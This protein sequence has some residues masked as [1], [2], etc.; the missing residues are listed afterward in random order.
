MSEPPSV[1]I[2]A[3][4]FIILCFLICRK[5]GTS[6]LFIPIFRHVCLLIP[7]SFQRGNL[8]AA[9]NALHI[10]ILF[11]H[12]WNHFWKHRFLKCNEISRPWS[13]ILKWIYALCTFYIHFIYMSIL[14]ICKINILFLSMNLGTNRINIEK[15]EWWLKSF[16]T[17]KDPDTYIL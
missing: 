3:S 9:A 6:H 12:H 1:P 10:P 13:C 2:S 4:L 7:L 17:P 16:I 15:S 11:A 14:F 5:N 8:S